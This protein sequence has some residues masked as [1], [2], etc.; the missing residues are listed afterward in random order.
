MQAYIIFSMTYG[1]LHRFMIKQLCKIYSVGE[2]KSIARLVF[3]DV[4]KLNS[5]DFFLEAKKEVTPAN[6]ARLEQIVKRLLQHEPVQYITGTAGFYGL[7]FKVNPHVLIP[8]PETEE[9]VKWILSD[10][11]NNPYTKKPAILDIGTGSGGIA[12][13]LK[14]NCA[15]AARFCHGYKR[16]GIN[17][18]APKCGNEQ[19]GS[20]FFCGRYSYL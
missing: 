16:R 7:K 19:G 10:I 8:R 5:I 20:E 1:E 9:L 13:V 3:E 17:S 2:A 15:D 4:L 6:Q 11:K 18:C 14:K 12:I